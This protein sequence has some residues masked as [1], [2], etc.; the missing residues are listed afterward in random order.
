MKCTVSLNGR[1]VPLAWSE[2]EGRIEFQ[3]GEDAP[4][5][6]ASVER[7]EPDLYSVLL[8]GRS[9]EARV[10]ETLDGLVVIVAGRRFAVGLEDPRAWSPGASRRHAEGR[11]DLKAPMPGKVVRV[12]VS[13]GDQVSAGQ[14][15]AV[16]EAMKMQNEL[17]T[18]K[19]GRVAA[20]SARPGASVNAGEI[21][22]T[23]E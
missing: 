1:S 11:H 18:P 6:S 3:F 9:I 13:E 8:D 23:I 15:I 2:R 10:E 21:L 22:A 17:K 12:L 5:R 4:V 20:L 16:V 7:V 14:G 19:A